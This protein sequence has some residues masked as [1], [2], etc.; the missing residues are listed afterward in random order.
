LINAPYCA[1]I[2]IDPSDLNVA[3]IAIGDL[4]GLQTVTRKVTNV[5]TS[6]ATYTASTTGLT[7]VTVNVSPNSLSLS[8]GQTGTFTVTFTRTTAARSSLV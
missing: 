6:A 3:S 7:G 1:S 8:P 4:A 5:G 2:A